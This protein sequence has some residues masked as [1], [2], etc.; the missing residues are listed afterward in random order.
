MTLPFKVLTFYLCSD[1]R[2]RPWPDRLKMILI[3]W[4]G[5]VAVYLSR[6][7]EVS[8][9]WNLCAR[10][11]VNC[12]TIK[13]IHNY[14]IKGLKFWTYSYSLVCCAI[15]CAD[16]KVRRSYQGVLR[17]RP[18]QVGRLRTHRERGSLQVC[19]SIHIFI[20]SYLW[21]IFM[22]SVYCIVRTPNTIFAP[23]RFGW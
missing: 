10:A 19:I 11:C 9:I 14:N 22:H 23:L 1:V 21:R 7:S 3:T 2:G 8:H 4:L 16:S 17:R 15:G 12:F 6:G 5:S 20:I 18:E 13:S